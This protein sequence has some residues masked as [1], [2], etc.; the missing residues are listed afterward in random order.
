M[1]DKTPE[2]RGTAEWST[3][4]WELG[5]VAMQNPLRTDFHRNKY[6]RNE[7]VTETKKSQ[8]TTA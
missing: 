3:R 2:I 6:I 8:A 7:A 1:D 4:R 5:D